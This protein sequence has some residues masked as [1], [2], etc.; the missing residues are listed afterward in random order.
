MVEHVGTEIQPAW[1]LQRSIFVDADLTEISRIAKFGEK[2]RSIGERT[3]V[4]Y[5][6]RP[7]SEDD[8]QLQTR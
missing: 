4:Q 3:E 1:P 6:L 7:I 2:A 5:A 8:L